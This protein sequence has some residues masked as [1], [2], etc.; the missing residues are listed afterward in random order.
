[1]ALLAVR[2]FR[3]RKRHLSR[4]ILSPTSSISE[5]HGAPLHRTARSDRPPPFLNYLL[6]EKYSGQDG[7]GWP[8][9]VEFPGGMD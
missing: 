5:A 6:T 3:L 2:L 9:L 4:S 8:G 7:M 1:M